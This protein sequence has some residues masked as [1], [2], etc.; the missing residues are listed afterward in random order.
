MPRPR[1]T[2]PIAGFCQH[3]RMQKTRDAA[4]QLSGAC[5][6]HPHPLD[7]HPGGRW[8]RRQVASLHTA[9]RCVSKVAIHLWQ[10]WLAGAHRPLSARPGCILA[11]L[12]TVPAGEGKAI[13]EQGRCTA[14]LFVHPCAGFYALNFSLFFLLVVNEQNPSEAL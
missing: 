7:N 10:G 13:G 5:G 12:P 14:C 1:T 2:N 6:R 3:C 8:G 11:S 9:P 4:A